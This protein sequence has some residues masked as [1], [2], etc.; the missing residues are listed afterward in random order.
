MTRN[1]GDDSEGAGDVH[2]ME[3]RVARLEEDM[4]DAKTALGR[5]EP[6]L[7]RIDERLGLDLRARYEHC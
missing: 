4:A 5:I 6:L 1:F 7:I 2:G 3:A